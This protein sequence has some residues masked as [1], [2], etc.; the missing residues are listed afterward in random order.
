[1]KDKKYIC[2]DCGHITTKEMAMKYH[3]QIHPNTFNGKKGTVL[4]KEED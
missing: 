1:M 4:W 2:T 3:R